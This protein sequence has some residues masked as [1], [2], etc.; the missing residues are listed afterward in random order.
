MAEMSVLAPRGP[1]WVLICRNGAGGKWHVQ[2]GDYD[3]QT[4]AV[5]LR[6]HVANGHRVRDLKIVRVQFDLQAAIDRQVAEL[7]R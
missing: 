5:E 3:R 6:E 2:F 4:V 1:Y 7:N